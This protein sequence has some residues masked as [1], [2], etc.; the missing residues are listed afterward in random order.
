MLILSAPSLRRSLKSSTVLI[1]PPTVNGIKTF[2]ATSL[3]M[4]TTVSLLSELA[5][6]SRKTTSSAPA[7]S[8]ALA[9]LTGSPASFKSTKFI[10]LTTLPSLTSRHGIIL[11]VCI[12]NL[13]KILKYLKPYI[14]AF[15]WMKLTCKNII[16]F[17]RCM[18]IYTIIASCSYNT[19]ILGFKII[20]MNKIHK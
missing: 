8:Y 12:L 17:N 6:I 19:F 20:R 13:R 18:N 2:A 4:S 15:L 10:P 11:L 9:T 7:L 16:L 1:P 14:R 5:V 3:T